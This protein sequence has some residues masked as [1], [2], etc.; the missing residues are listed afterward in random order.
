MRAFRIAIDERCSCSRSREPPTKV[1]KKLRLHE[2]ETIDEPED[3]VVLC[4]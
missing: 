1:R 3:G 2:F 4:R